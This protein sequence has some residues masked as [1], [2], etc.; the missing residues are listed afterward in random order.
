MKIAI[1]CAHFR[2][3]IGYQEVYIANACARLKHEVTVFTTANIP[4]SHKLII[5]TNSILDYIRENSPINLYKLSRELK[6]PYSTISDII[7]F[8]EISKLIKTETILNKQNRAEKIIY[9]PKE[10]ETHEKK[11]EEKNEKN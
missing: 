1:V 8:F 7:K 3:E 11:L 2:P 4:K 6:I 9:F 5:K 10:K